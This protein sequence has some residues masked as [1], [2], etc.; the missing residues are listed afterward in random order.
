MV[1]GLTEMDGGCTYVTTL[2]VVQSTCALTGS[3]RTHRD[4]DRNQRQRASMYGPSRGARTIA[5][6]TARRYRVPGLSPCDTGGIVMR[7]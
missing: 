2:R 4:G 7:A 3:L 1:E 5:Y 6:V